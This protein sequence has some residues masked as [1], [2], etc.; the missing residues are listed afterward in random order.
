MSYEDIATSINDDKAPA[1]QEDVALGVLDR[2]ARTGVGRAGS[3]AF[4]FVGPQQPAV[5][6]LAGRNFEFKPA[7]DLVPLGTYG[8]LEDVCIL[9]LTPSEHWDGLHSAVTAVFSGLASTAQVAPLDLGP[10]IHALQALF[11]S[12]LRSNVT[13]EV[14]IGLAGELIAI[15]YANDRAAMAER[16][17]SAID[18]AFDL[19]A[20]GERLEIKTTTAA[21]RVHWVS[22]RQVT[23]VPGVCVSFLSVVLPLVAH[24]TTVSEVYLT[25]ADLPGETVARIR[26]TILATAG[27]PPELLTGVQFDLTAALAGLRHVEA[28]ALPAPLPVPGVRGMRWEAEFPD[29]SAAALGCQFADILALQ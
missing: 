21:E 15:A 18:D 27:A 22:S 20:N 28:D 26:S 29:S 1:S 12:D 3:G 17:H 19:S 9:R 23:E 8:R 11:E 7:T 25:L 2:L 14:E 16:W 10:A 24:G 5:Q 4:V 13:R 6:A